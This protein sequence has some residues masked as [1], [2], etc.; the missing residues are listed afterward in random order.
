MLLIVLTDH[1]SSTKWI[2]SKVLA[3]D[4]TTTPCFSESLTMHCTELIAIGDI[5]QDGDAPRIGTYDKVILV[6]A[7]LFVIERGREEEDDD[8]CMYIMYRRG[9]T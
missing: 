7:H 2:S 9:L 8:L 6:C 4:D 5:L 3:R 1:N